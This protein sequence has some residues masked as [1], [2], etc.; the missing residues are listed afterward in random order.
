MT[1]SRGLIAWSIAAVVLVLAAY[2]IGESRTPRGFDGP[3][4][5]YLALAVLIPLF[6]YLFSVGRMAVVG[7]APAAG[8]ETAAA[9]KTASGAPAVCGMSGATDATDG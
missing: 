9:A 4:L 7:G 6:V 5:A 1:R 8:G 3:R 2:W